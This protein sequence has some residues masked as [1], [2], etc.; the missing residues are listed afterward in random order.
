MTFIQS[1]IGMVLAI[2]PGKCP[3]GDKQC[4]SIAARCVVFDTRPCWRRKLRS[5]TPGPF[6][7]ASIPYW[8]GE[9]QQNRGRQGRKH[10]SSSG[11]SPT[12]SRFS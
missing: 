9:S 11:N 1:F 8:L 3:A 2:R 4:T 5:L 7:G 6:N 12:G 10:L